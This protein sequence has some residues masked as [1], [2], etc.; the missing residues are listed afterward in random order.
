MIL[1]KFVMFIQIITYIL[2]PIMVA[3][4]ATV[5]AKRKEVKIEAQGQLLEHRIQAYSKV[6]RFMSKSMSLI[7][8]PNYQKQLYIDCL[9]GSEYKID[10]QSMKYASFLSHIE[11]LEQYY[12]QLDELVLENGLHLESKLKR[13]LNYFWQWMLSVAQLLKTFKAIEDDQQY[14]LPENVKKNMIRYACGLIGVALQ[15]DVQQFN[16]NIMPL[17]EDKLRYPRIRKWSFSEDDNSYNPK[18]NSYTQSQ[19][20]THISDIIIRLMYLHYSFQYP[21]NQFDNLPEE[22][23]SRLVNAFFESFIRHYDEYYT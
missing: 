8:I 7:A 18:E 1:W 23:R 11:S 21:S 13:E 5:M 22:K 3:Y 2:L 19:L 20:V 15:A 12:N 6:Y 9:E 14:K 16:K 4:I 10:S 17:L